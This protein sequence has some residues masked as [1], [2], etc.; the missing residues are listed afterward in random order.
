M[1]LK[2]STNAPNFNLPN[3]NGETISLSD[4]KGKYVYIDVWATWCGPC[5]AEIPSLKKVEKLYHN[6]NIEF[7]SISIDV[8][9]RP[10]YNYDK[11]PINFDKSYVFPYLEKGSSYLI[12]EFPNEKEYED[13]KEKV[14]SL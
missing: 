4:L 13:A 12:K 6:K 3:Q 8:R 9:D 1:L 10:V 5:I 11:W 14:Q 7:V 2:V